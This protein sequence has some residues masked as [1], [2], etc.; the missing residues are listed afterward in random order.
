MERKGME[1]FAPLS[2]LVFLV[3][4]IASIVVGGEPPSADDSTAEVVEF[5]D[6]NE[7]SQLASSILGAWAAA[8]LVWF[9]ASVR[10]AVVRVEGG[11]SRL[12]SIALAGTVLTA[13]GITMN[14]VFQ[15]AAADVHDDVPPEV[16]QTISVLYADTF[17]PM[18]AG[19]FLFLLAAGIAAIRHGAF[20][21]RLA[22]IGIVIGVL[23]ITP[24]GFFAFIAWLVWIGIAAILLYREKDPVGSG[25]APPPT[26]G[27]SIEVPPGQ[28][29]PSPA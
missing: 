28:G 4:A 9:G 2:G 14:A 6:E 5:W 26:S 15:F 17:F 19:N 8:A 25:A 23:S 1:R 12:G 21:K 22:W 18:A 10:E 13:A 27:P 20:D 3:L 16:L 11:P 7:G 24:A 29:P